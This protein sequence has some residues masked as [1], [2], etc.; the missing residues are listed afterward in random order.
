MTTSNKAGQAL[1]IV[2]ASVAA[3]TAVAMVVGASPRR[4]PRRRRSMPNRA[5]MIAALGL[6][7]E[8]PHR[9][10]RYAATTKEF[11]HKV[12]HGTYPAAAKARRTL[13]IED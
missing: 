7:P 12:Q 6:D 9:N 1:A 2:A 8:G 13:G 4:N 5:D 10:D 3:A 11:W